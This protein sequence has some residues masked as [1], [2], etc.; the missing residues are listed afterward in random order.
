[1]KPSSAVKYLYVHTEDGSV[2]ALLFAV[3][4][5]TTAACVSCRK[6]RWKV[7]HDGNSFIKVFTSILHFN[8]VTKIGILQMS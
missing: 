1:M 3:K 2:E 7:L 4:R 6:M 5:L 8:N